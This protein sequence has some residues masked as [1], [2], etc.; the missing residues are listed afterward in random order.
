MIISPS[1]YKRTIMLVFILSMNTSIIFSQ[2]GFVKARGWTVS[3]Y[4]NTLNK[5]QNGITYTNFTYFEAFNDGTHVNGPSW[6]LTVRANA[7]FING[8]PLGVVEIWANIAAVNGTTTGWQRLDNTLTPVTLISNGA[9][10]S[11]MAIDISYRV[12][13]ITNTVQMSG[14][15]SDFYSVDLI[16]EMVFHP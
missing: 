3:F 9:I 4:F 10:G 16:F 15:P 11:N 2:N 5:I 12:G 6:D 7:T 1:V 13:D 8:L 14:Y